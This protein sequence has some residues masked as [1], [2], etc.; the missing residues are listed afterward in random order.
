MAGLHM[1]ISSQKFL[2]IEEIARTS[3]D[4]IF[5]WNPALNYQALL[6]QCA[7]TPITDLRPYLLV[8][9]EAPIPLRQIVKIEND[10]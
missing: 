10:R 2:A 4:L 7:Y 5:T 6:R 8:F 3:D 9:I 1:K